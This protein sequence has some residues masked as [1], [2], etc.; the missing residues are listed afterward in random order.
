MAHPQSTT[1]ASRS[2]WGGG[3]KRK[4]TFQSAAG[5]PA[6]WVGRSPACGRRPVARRLQPM[7][8]QSAPS[9]GMATGQKYTPER[10]RM[11]SAPPWGAATGGVVT[12]VR[13]SIRARSGARAGAG[14]N[15]HNWISIRAPQLRG[16]KGGTLPCMMFQ[17]A[18]G[19]GDTF[20]AA[21]QRLKT[22]SIRAWGEAKAFTRGAAG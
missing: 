9:R 21:C 20:H 11:Q 3:C 15:K 2:P 16:R 10:R 4:K 7:P 22:V 18:P 14:P 17:S 13:V 19:Q 12:T 1:V 8:F 5:E 6:E